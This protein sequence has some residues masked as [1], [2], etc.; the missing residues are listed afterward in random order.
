MANKSQ[1]NTFPRQS[2]G[3]RLLRPVSESPDAPACENQQLI[4]ENFQ[5]LSKKIYNA[6]LT[7]KIQQS[8]SRQVEVSQQARGK[9]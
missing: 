2:K 8:K 6:K 1:N 7:T 5:K 3:S 9:K 4:Q